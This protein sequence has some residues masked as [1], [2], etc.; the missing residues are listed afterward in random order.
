MWTRSL[1][2][3]PTGAPF[4][5]SNRPSAVSAHSVSL[6]PVQGADRLPA[7]YRRPDWLESLQVFKQGGIIDRKPLRLPEFPKNRSIR[8]PS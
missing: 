6:W 1:S 5:G 2:L 7:W 8:R 4:E 3:N